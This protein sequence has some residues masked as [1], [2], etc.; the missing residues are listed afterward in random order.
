MKLP[1]LEALDIAIVTM[2]AFL[3]LPLVNNESYTL[4]GRSPPSMR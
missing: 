4:R 1:E 2:L 3:L